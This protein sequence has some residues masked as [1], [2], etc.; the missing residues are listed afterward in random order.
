MAKR[1]FYGLDG[2]EK[3]E[4]EA[5]KLLE[6]AATQEYPEA[7]YWLGRFESK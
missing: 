6:L 2:E 1:L 4:I 3:N 5:R 7:W